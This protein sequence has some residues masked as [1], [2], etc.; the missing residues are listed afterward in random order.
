MDIYE[1]KLKISAVN[2]LFDKRDPSTAA[3]IEEMYGPQGG[4]FWKIKFI[5]SQ[6]CHAQQIN[7]STDPCINHISSHSKSL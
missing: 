1:G 5:W 4:L 3:Q 6:V 2:D 7:F